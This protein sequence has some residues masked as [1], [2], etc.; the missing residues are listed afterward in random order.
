VKASIEP[1]VVLLT[2]AWHGQAGIERVGY[3]HK[4]VSVRASIEEAAS[5]PQARLSA[6]SPRQSPIT[7]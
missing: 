2:D 1:A 6:E 7:K 3:I 5:V 4:P